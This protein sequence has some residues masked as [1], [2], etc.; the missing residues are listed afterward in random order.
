M[1]ILGDE[2]AGAR[3]LDLYAG[4]GA[5]GLEALS[6]G[7]ASADF[8]ELNPP[9]LTALR[10]NIDAA[11]RRRPGTGPSG[12]RAAVRRAARGRRVRRGLRRPA[13]HR[14]RR[15]AGWS[16]SSAG[17]LRAHP[18]RRAP[19][20]PAPR[21][22]RHPPLRRHRHHLLPRPMTRIAIYPGSFDPPTR[23]HEDLIRRS[24]ALADRVI[25]AVA[26]NAAK[27]PLF[28]VEERLRCSGRRSATSRGSP[29]SRSR[30]CWP[31]SP[32]RSGA[33][34]IVRGLRAVSDFEYE[35]QMALMNRQLH[36][37]ARDRLPGAG[38][39]PHVPELEPGARGGAV[40]RRRER[41][42]CI[43]PSPPRSAGGSAH[44]L[45]RRSCSSGPRPAGADRALRGR[46][47][48]GPG[49]GG[50]APARG[51]RRADRCSAASG[52]EPANDPRLGAR[53]AAPPRA[54]ARP[55]PG[56]R[57]RARRRRRSRSTSPPRWWRWA[58]RTAA[59][60]GAVVPTADV[61]RAA[62]WAIGTA[63]GMRPGE[64]GVLHGAA[65][66]HA[67][68]PSPTARWC[69][70]RRRTQLA[71]IALAA[72]RDRLRLVGDE[73]RVAFLPTA[74]R[75]A[76][77]GRGWTGCGRRRRASARWRPRSPSDGELQ[78]DA[79]LDAEVGER[80]APGSPV[81]GR[82]NVLVFPD[83]DAGNIAYK[84]VQ[85]LAG[86]VAIGPILQGLAR[87]MADLSRGATRRR[88][89]R[90]GRDGGAA[91]RHRRPEGDDR[92]GFTRSKT[93][94][95]WR[96]CRSKAS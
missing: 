83:L 81:A 41:R 59:V 80:K 88:Y 21:R 68:S 51:H 20:R 69:P 24:L 93:R 63:P 35:F 66:R 28:P 39:R 78:G 64:L 12:R 95:G 87:P 90:G 72:A 3:V 10:A 37:V 45:P 2:L 86:A 75:G 13:L 9:S 17:P 6:R 26:V 71:E 89:C 92:M 11:R 82:A 7:A 18:F 76:P 56:R 79:A 8:V 62:L 84:L 42:W 31:S 34:M 19:S 94:A 73:P 46:R 55:G 58:R 4:S 49:R 47:P 57:P 36:P 29:S 70:S 91:V 54:P 61:I 5:L 50:T 25:V 48:A 44:E 43:P 30:G 77:R 33:S 53:R 38:G 1:S 27:Q 65:R 85:R 15:R 40:R 23:G 22:R 14:R 67:C 74:P 32:G 52:L 16:R 60:A 96:W